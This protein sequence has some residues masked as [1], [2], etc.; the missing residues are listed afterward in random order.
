[1][2]ILTSPHTKPESCPQYTYTHTHNTHTHNT[3]THSSPRPDSASASTQVLPDTGMLAQR[4]QAQ[5]PPPC[6]GH[7]GVGTGIQHP[8]AFHKPRRGCHLSNLGDLLYNLLK[9]NPVKI[10]SFQF[11][12]VTTFSLPNNRSCRCNH[13]RSKWS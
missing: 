8:H 10:D 6:S 3:H 12:T 5:Q 2:E 7:G 13:L 4:G 1:M 11:C 9:K